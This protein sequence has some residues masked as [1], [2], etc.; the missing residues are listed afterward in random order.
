MGE[1]W[2]GLSELCGLDAIPSPRCLWKGLDAQGI[3]GLCV[4]FL[5][6]TGLV[7][8]FLSLLPALSFLIPSSLSNKSPARLQTC[9][10][11]NWKGKVLRSREIFMV[12]LTCFTE[13]C[14]FFP[15]KLQTS[16]SKDKM[17]RE[18]PTAQLFQFC[19]AV[20][21]AFQDLSRC[22]GVPEI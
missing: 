1:L 12:A 16:A 8:M 11:R 18:N 14:P 9:R 3:K 22:W 21:F 7:S 19:W 5:M 10:C 6:T 15:G 2:G 4:I 17:V 13:K 20:W